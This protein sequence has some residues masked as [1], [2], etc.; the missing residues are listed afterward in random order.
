MFDFGLGLGLLGIWCFVIRYLLWFGL[1]F[2]WW[3]VMVV[4]CVGWFGR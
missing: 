1:V 2:V 4:L 3:F